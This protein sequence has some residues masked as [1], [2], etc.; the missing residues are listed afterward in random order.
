MKDN[1]ERFNHI[2]DFSSKEKSRPQSKDAD[3]ITD[4]LL[5]DGLLKARSNDGV[6]SPYDKQ[7][8]VVNAYMKAIDTLLKGKVD[9]AMLHNIAE[10]I[11][12][13]EEQC[14]DISKDDIHEKVKMV[15]EN[16]HKAFPSLKVE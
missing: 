7:A 1:L 9:E 11:K 8:N 6:L 16:N 3:I 2:S 12:G 10:T 13:I 5:K 4:K 15:F 14:P